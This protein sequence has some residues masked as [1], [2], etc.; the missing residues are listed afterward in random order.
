MTN[1]PG[2]IHEYVPMGN[3]VRPEPVQIQA[4]PPYVFNHLE[5][6]STRLK[7]VFWS[8]RGN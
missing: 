6:I 5:N 1:E 8:D 2:V 7:E 4:L 3:N